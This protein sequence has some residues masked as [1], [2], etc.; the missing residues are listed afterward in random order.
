MKQ[1]ESC[2]NTDYTD[3]FKISREKDGSFVAVKGK[4]RLKAK[5]AK[6]IKE[7]IQNFH[8]PSADKTIKH[9]AKAGSSHDECVRTIA[10]DLKKDNWLVR[11]NTEGYEK[12]VEIGDRIPDIVAH[13]GCQKRICQIVSKKDFEGDIANYRDF[14]NYCKDYDFQ[15]YIVDKN[16]KPKNV[17]F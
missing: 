8:E 5:S 2:E 4:Y 12:P 3:G 6:E 9:T 1:R 15:L 16:G 11:A 17:E 7:L 13:K 10:E 14:R